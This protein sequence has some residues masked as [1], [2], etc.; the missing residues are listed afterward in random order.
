MSEVQDDLKTTWATYESLEYCEERII[1]MADILC[2]TRS[3]LIIKEKEDIKMVHNG[4]KMGAVGA[5][6]IPPITRYKVNQ[7]TPSHLSIDFP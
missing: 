1:L 2:D 3:Y 5:L 4:P 7:F 6:H